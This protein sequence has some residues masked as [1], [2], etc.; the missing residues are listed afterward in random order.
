MQPLLSVLQLLPYYSISICPDVFVGI[1]VAT[2]RH[3]DRHTCRPRYIGSNRPHLMLC[4]AMQH[5]NIYNDNKEPKLKSQS[6]RILLQQWLT[7]VAPTQTACCMVSRSVQTD[8][9]CHACHSCSNNRTD[10]AL[11]TEHISTECPEYLAPCM[12]HSLCSYASHLHKN[13]NNNNGCIIL[14]CY[15]NK[16]YKQMS[17]SKYDMRKFYFTNRVDDQ[18][19]S[20][21]NRVVTANNTKIFNKWLDQYWQHQDIIFDFRAQIEGTGSRSE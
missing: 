8:D 12:T 19:N 5:T 21:P 16:C 20:L 9:S 13:N 17:R 4:T 14:S 6:Q 18:W 15:K 1:T 11:D 3:T 2:N 7:V 10:W